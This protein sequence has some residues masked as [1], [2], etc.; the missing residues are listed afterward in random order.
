MKRFQ[1]I[2]ALLLA[3]FAVLAL[4]GGIHA[5]AAVAQTTRSNSGVTEE[6]TDVEVPLRPAKTLQSIRIDT[7]PGKLTYR[8]GEA[9]ELSGLV[10][11]ATYSDNSTKPVTTYQV[12]GFDPNKLGD[13]TVTVSLGGKIATFQVNVYMMGDVDGTGQVASVD[14]AL[15][16]Q[17]AAGWDVTFNLQAA[18]VNGD[19][20]VT[21]VDATLILQYAA[22]WDVTLG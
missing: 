15:I 1:R 18:D 12:S 7:M 22:G 10:V 21:G 19:T 6:D 4:L 11:I 20:E 9:L 3:V 13:Q 2:V 17:Y 8:K 14:A 16:L 5:F